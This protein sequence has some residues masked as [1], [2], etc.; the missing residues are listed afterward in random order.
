M[1]R[2]LLW[3]NKSARF[4][5]IMSLTV[6]ILSLIAPLITPFS[7]SEF[8]SDILRPP[9]RNHLFGTDEYG[10][11]LFSRILRG[12]LITLRI[13]IVSLSLAATFGILWGLL[14]AYIRGII[15]IIFNRF[16]DVLMS[17]PSIM[18]A[19][20][21]LAIFGTS[22][23][24]PLIIA[25]AIALS[26][27]FARVIRGSTLPI[28]EED[29]VLAAQAL[30]A[31][32]IRILMRHI[33]PNLMSPII[34]L[35]TI[36]LPFIIILESA[37]SFLGLGAPPDVPTWGLIISDG[38]AYMQL[39]PW[40]TLFPGMAIIFTGISFNVLGDGLRDI[41]DPRSLLRGT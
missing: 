32:H 18:V 38:K 31:S 13:A 30:G 2:L 37:L 14:A 8:S 35:I 6:I 36:Y 23:K 22:G 39:A 16:I 10:R 3:K 27:S 40:L 12:S 9:S 11:D 29:F 33:L 15:G 26:P 20:F 17:F 19:L 5:G 41:L 28:L 25:I 21:V 4:G 34:V 1:F 7:P 24:T